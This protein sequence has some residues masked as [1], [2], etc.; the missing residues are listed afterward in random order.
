[1]SISPQQAAEA[2]QA[3]AQ[4]QQRSSILRGYEYGAPHFLLWG[5]IWV[6]GF[7]CTELFAAQVGRIWLALDII[8]IGGSYLLVRAAP[9]GISIAAPAGEASAAK[10]WRFLGAGLAITA[11]MGGTYYVMAP[12]TS[13]QYGAFPALMMAFLYTLTGIYR[14]P[15]WAV[16]GIALWCLTVLG[17]AVLREHFM[18]WMAA[19]GGSS[20][21]LTGF[22]MR[23]A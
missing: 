13:A 9:S 4:T 8:G 23:R 1:M 3:V 10:S 15:R 22:W 21:L 6:V 17:Y 12:H 20:L 7:G 11:F 14:G 18:L 2:L 19:V 5:C 16:I